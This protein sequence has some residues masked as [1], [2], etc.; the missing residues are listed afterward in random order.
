MER[1]EGILLGSES[2]SW[3][4]NSSGVG[5]SGVSGADPGEDGPSDILKGVGVVVGGDQ[6]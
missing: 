5:V 3:P 1:S 6:Q 2:P 4:T